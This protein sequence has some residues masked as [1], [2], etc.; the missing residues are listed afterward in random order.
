MCSSLASTPSHEPR[1]PRLIAMQCCMR[2]R[3]SFVSLAGCFR[4]VSGGLLLALLL[5]YSSFGW[6]KND[7][8]FNAVKEPF[9]ATGFALPDRS[10]NQHRLSD[11]KGRVVVINFWSTWCI[12]CRKEMPS[13]E[14]AWQRLQS[15]DVELL[16]IAMQ[17]DVEAIDLFLEK[18]P[19]SFPVLLDS[20][21][22]V[23]REW[24]VIG[25]PVTFVLDGAG[26][27]VY[28][29]KGIREWDCDAIVNKIVN[30][31]ER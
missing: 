26:R 22:E 15:S 25:I 19:V 21:G 27:V 30:L 12:P 20:D 29:I 14:R 13:L 10:G 4:V 8:R 17:D 18:S 2:Q 28:A 3:I 9:A 1:Y 6:A 16:S 7:C 31:A 11:Y 5:V 23:A 24:K